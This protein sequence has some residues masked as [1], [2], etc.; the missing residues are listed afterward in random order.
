MLLFDTQPHLAPGSSALMDE[1][2]G[3]NSSPTAASSDTISNPSDGLSHGSSSSGGSPGPQD[4]MDCQQDVGSW[5]DQ[6]INV[7]GKWHPE[8]VSRVVV[9]ASQFRH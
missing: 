7:T 2:P 3:V 5:L 1:G 4:V 6:G 9:D 8:L